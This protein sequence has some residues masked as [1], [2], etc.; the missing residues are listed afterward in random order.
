[1]AVGEESVMPMTVEGRTLTLACSISVTAT[2]WLTFL[3]WFRCIAGS[4]HVDVVTHK[5]GQPLQSHLL[6]PGDNWAHLAGSINWGNGYSV[7]HIRC[8]QNSK[9]QMALPAMLL[10]DSVGQM[11]TA[12]LPSFEY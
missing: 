9:F 3:S 5:N 6:Q 4:V 12:P 7:V 11:H 1:M 10:G 2:G 8:E